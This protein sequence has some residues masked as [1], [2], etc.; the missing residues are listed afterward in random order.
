MENSIM[1]GE[2]IKLKLI[3][4][5]KTNQ[6][7]YA[8]V[9]KYKDLV[10][11]VDI[12]YL[13]DKKLIKKE[14]PNSNL[15]LAQIETIEYELIT[16]SDKRI[17]SNFKDNFDK[18][19]SYEDILIRETKYEVLSEFTKKIR[20]LKNNPTIYLISVKLRDDTGVTDVYKNNSRRQNRLNYQCSQ[21]SDNIQL[22]RFM[23]C[24][25][26]KLEGYSKELNLKNGAYSNSIKEVSEPT[27][28][29]PS[30]KTLLGID[31]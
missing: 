14:L 11:N 10:V 5:K 8:G 2:S 19:A 3:K 26:H 23:N 4:D 20:F 28:Y 9:N 31:D 25:G 12:S 24:Y 6:C 21:I 16:R 1:I 15:I 22:L 17:P 30:I 27:T 7:Y 29:V 18:K 13:N